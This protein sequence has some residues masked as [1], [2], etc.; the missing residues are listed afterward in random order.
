MPDERRP[1]H[2]LLSEPLAR[3]VIILSANPAQ[4]RESLPERESSRHRIIR[5]F[6]AHFQAP[7][8]LKGKAIFRRQILKTGSEFPHKSQEIGKIT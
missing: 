6:K 5:T 1:R 8:R 3:S 4:N 7:K 2:F